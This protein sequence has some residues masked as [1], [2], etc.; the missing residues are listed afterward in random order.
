MKTVDTIVEHWKQLFLDADDRKKEQLRE[1]VEAVREKQVGM[2]YPAPEIQKVIV[3]AKS[4]DHTQR[5]CNVWYECT[6][7]AFL[8]SGKGHGSSNKKPCK[9][10]YSLACKLIKGELNEY[11]Q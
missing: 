8:C 10:L 2:I 5:L 3:L 11:K 7:H 9:H 1:R 4:G 6:C